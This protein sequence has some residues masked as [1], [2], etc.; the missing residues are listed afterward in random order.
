MSERPDWRCE[1]C[2]RGFASARGLAS[3]NGRVHPAPRPTRAKIAPTCKTCGAYVSDRKLHQ[4]W[5]A[6]LDA[7]ASSARL[8]D[9]MLRPIGPSFTVPVETDHVMLSWLKLSNGS[10]AS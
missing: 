1:P 5:H 6:N 7:I 2:D 9:T 3:H 4:E 10:G 8:A